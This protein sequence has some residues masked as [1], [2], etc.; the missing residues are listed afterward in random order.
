MSNVPSYQSEIETKFNSFLNDQGISDKT[1]SNYRSDSKHFLEWAIT[2]N[3]SVFSN[4]ENYT[5]F[6]S[7]VTPEFLSA[8]RDLQLSTGVPA[9][10]VNRRLSSIRMLF[11]WATDSE[12]ITTN[13]TLTLK[14]STIPTDSSTQTIEG[15]LGA[16]EQSLRH[17]GAADSTV[18]N[19]VSDAQQFLLWLANRGTTYR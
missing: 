5:T 16:F 12:I 8:Y 11:K 18:K 14:N 13:P 1:I 2:H 4:V 10:T 9:A 7:L 6:F 3:A 17:E 15:M 19:Y